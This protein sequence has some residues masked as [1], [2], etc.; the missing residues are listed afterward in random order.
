MI[1]VAKALK[2]FCQMCGKKTE[3]H[4]VFNIFATE[5]AVCH[6]LV[7]RMDRLAKQS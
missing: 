3:Q 6:S 2:V 7:A 1:S 4:Y 5:C